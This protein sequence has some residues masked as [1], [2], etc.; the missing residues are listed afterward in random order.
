MKEVMASFCEAAGTLGLFSRF[1]PLKQAH[2]RLVA[3]ASRDQRWEV[4]PRMALGD[5]DGETKI[6]VAGNSTSSSI[7]PMHNLHVSAA[8]DSR[9]V[10]SE[11][12][13]TVKTR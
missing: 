11:L 2:Q 6:N 7:L 3:L 9:H 13:S 1:E 4:A 8:P 12:A 5:K 10:G